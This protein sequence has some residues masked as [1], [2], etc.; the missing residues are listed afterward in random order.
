MPYDVILASS[1]IPKRTCMIGSLFCFRP[2]SSLRVCGWLTWI[3][4]IFKNISSLFSGKPDSWDKCD[5]SANV[6]HQCHGLTV[7][8]SNLDGK[9]LHESRLGNFHVNV[10]WFGDMNSS[11]WL[12][13]D[14]PQWRLTKHGF[15]PWSKIEE[16]HWT[17]L[18]LDQG[19]F[20]DT[21][22][23][24]PPTNMNTS[25]CTWIWKH[26]LIFLAT[27]KPISPSDIWQLLCFTGRGPEV[28]N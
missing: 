12:K 26:Q 22:H 15:W 24:N 9:I 4:M 21:N 18:K 14:E 8:I 2:S 3:L 17:L 16:H 20:H 1:G 27:L 5:K 11:E 13:E 23:E 25:W 10:A 28:E 7:H 6:R 19:N